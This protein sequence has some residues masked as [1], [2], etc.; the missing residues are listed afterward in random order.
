MA[1]ATVK[2]TSPCADLVEIKAWVNGNGVKGAKVRMALIEEKQETLE[3]ALKKMDANIGKA[4]GWIVGAACTFIV[5]VLIWI[6]TNLIPKLL[7][8]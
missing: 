5:G 3:E 2:H 4:V 6:F 8:G 1:E 7:A